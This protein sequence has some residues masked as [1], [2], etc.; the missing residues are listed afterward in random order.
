MKTVVFPEPVGKD[1]PIAKSLRRVHTRRH[2]NNV[3]DTDQAK[4]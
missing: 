3:L 2:P 1:M 4:A